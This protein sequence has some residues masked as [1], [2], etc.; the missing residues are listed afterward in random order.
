MEIN[1]KFEGFLNRK[2]INGYV[3]T[4]ESLSYNNLVKEG[5]NQ[6][7]GF[8]LAGMRDDSEDFAIITNN[9]PAITSYSFNDIKKLNSLR[10]LSKAD[11]RFENILYEVEMT[12]N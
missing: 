4:R 1:G 8:L 5:D 3:V 12:I 7:S 10:E 11:K 2:Y 6:V 9:P